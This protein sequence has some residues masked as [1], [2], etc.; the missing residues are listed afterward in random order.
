MRKTWIVT[1]EISFEIEAEEEPSTRALELYLQACINYG[2][3]G[4]ML[5]TDD[6][7]VDIETIDEVA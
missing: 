1:G 4:G 6:L 3:D 2:M 7:R 5:M